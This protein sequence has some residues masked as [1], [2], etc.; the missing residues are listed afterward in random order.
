[1]CT[2]YVATII[3]ASGDTPGQ[4][5]ASNMNFLFW[6]DALAAV[7]QAY[8]DQCIWAHNEQNQDDLLDIATSVPASF[9][10]D[11]DQ[12]R[13]GENLYAWDDATGLNDGS[14][15]F[16]AFMESGVNGWSVSSLENCGHLILFF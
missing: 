2:F 11:P 15:D 9:G 3:D 12:L 5:S 8:A 6:D 14:Y 7:A 1:M 13:L 16:N 10:Y 4:P